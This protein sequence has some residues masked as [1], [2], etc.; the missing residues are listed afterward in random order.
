MMQTTKKK[1]PGSIVIIERALSGLRRAAASLIIELPA[2]WTGIDRLIERLEKSGRSLEKRAAAAGAR[3]SNAEVLAHI[4]GI[5]R[6]GQRRLRVLLGELGTLD[7]YDFYRPKEKDLAALRTIFQTT[8]QET[9]SL[10]KSLRMAGIDLGARVLH[11]QLGEISLLGW[12]YYLNLHARIES[13]RI[14]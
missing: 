14:Y 9:I 1:A 2:R 13:Q 8:R 5:E 10:C 6:W 11:N 3:S 12:L 4:I 7:E